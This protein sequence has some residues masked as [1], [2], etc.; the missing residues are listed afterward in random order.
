[1]PSA[2]TALIRSD[3]CGKDICLAIRLVAGANQRF[4]E[5]QIVVG[6]AQRSGTLKL[7]CIEPGCELCPALA[8]RFLIDVDAFCARGADRESCSRLF[9]AGETIGFAEELR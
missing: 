1:M 5:V 4:G 2:V 7:T 3:I 6:T 8:G 9:M